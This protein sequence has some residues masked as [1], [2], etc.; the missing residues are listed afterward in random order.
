VR[1]DKVCPLRKGKGKK[2]DAKEKEE[3]Q[4]RMEGE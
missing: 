4:G 1:E 3:G 2:G